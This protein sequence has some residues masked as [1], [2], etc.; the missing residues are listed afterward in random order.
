MVNQ[1]HRQMSYWSV[2]DS[3]GKFLGLTN[4]MKLMVEECKTKYPNGFRIQRYEEN[5]KKLNIY[6][7]VPEGSM[8][9]RKERPQSYSWSRIHQT[10]VIE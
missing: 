8:W 10:E 6:I 1:P 5:G 4:K 9:A 3:D 2:Y 7:Y